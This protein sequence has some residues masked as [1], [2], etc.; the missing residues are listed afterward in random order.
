[1]QANG[2]GASDAAFALPHLLGDQKVRGRAQ[3]PAICSAETA[4]RPGGGGNS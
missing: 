1:L 3:H 4:G 2:N